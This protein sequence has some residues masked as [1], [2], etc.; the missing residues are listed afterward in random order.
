M[1]RALILGLAALAAAVPALAQTS[2]SPF[3]YGTR[4]DAMRRVTGTIAPDPDDAGPLVFAAVRNTYD[5]AGRLVKV[6]KGELSS[7]Q[8]E[9]IALCRG[10]QSNHPLQAQL[11]NGEVARADPLLRGRQWR[12]RA[13]F[14]AIPALMLQRLGRIGVDLPQYPISQPVEVAL[15]RL[16]LMDRLDL[17]MRFIRKGI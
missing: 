10:G 17:E 2:P 11:R 3:T 6:E 16:P 7:W 4:Y 9:A 15:H 13:A 14:E 8:S 1:I 5:A 12:G